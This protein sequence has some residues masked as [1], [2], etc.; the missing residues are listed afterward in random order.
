MKA[1]DPLYPYNHKLIIE[2]FAYDTSFGGDRVYLGADI[3]AQ[4][5][6][7]RTSPFDLESNPKTEPLR[8]FAV[9]KGVG[10][11][12]EPTCAIL[13]Q[14]DIVLSTDEELC[15]VLWRSSKG[16]YKYL[17]MRNIHECK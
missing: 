17:K 7:R 5:R 12:T 16:I 3:V 9:V 6:S 1:A 14:R 2:G 10:S 8:W 13:L 11:D 4:F 15:H